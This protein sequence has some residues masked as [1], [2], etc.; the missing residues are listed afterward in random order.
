MS[1]SSFVTNQIM[2]TV[3]LAQIRGNKM[4]FPMAVLGWAWK[5]NI[6]VTNVSFVSSPKG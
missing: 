1:H 5:L 6:A 4:V 3:S 2:T